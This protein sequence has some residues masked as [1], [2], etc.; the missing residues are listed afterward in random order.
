MVDEADISAEA[1]ETARRA[2]V[3]AVLGR[4]KT[5]AESFTECQE[6]GE[7]IPEAR[8]RAA[9]GCRLCIVCARKSER[10]TERLFPNGQ[11]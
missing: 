1:E 3:A 8:R 9:P 5:A 7:E 11:S 2:S 10:V 6:C 4:K